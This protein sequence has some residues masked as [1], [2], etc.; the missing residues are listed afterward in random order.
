M[1]VANPRAPNPDGHI[2][3]LAPPGAP[4]APDH[5]ADAFTWDAFIL[6]GD[7]TDPASGAL[8][9]PGTTENGW[10]TDP[11]NI[12]IDPSGRLWIT[13]DGPPDAGFNDALYAMDT[14]GPGRALPRL[15]YL[16]PVGSEVCS[17][18]FTPDGTTM[19]ISVQ[20]PGELRLEDG[21]DATS[22]ADAGTAWPDFTGGPA[23]PSLVVLTREDGGIVGS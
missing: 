15:F 14:E 10:F 4:D 16:P 5:A 3:E 6:C 12:G 2:L 22:I 18:A 7:P 8:V 11:D 9:H 23:R 13:T 20:H 1:N 19:F 21:D 17:P